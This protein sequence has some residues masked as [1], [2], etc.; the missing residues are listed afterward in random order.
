[1]TH[2]TRRNRERG[3]RRPGAAGGGAPASGPTL[4]IGIV[5]HP[6]VGGSGVVATS[7]GSA[8]ARQGHRVHFFGHEA[9]FRLDLRQENVL[10]HPV[11]PF[12]YPLFR[13]P[14][15]C[16][17][18]ASRIAEAI[19]AEGL[20]LV[21]AHYAVPNAA[22]ALFAREIAGSG[23]RPRIVTTLH[24][25]DIVLVGHDPS[26]RNATRYSMERA[27]AVTAVSEWL[28][29][30][31][32]LRFNLS[33]P[34]RV[35]PNFVDAASFRPDPTRPRP[36]EG[37]RLVHLSNFRAVKQVRHV[38][39][40][41]AAL[42][43]RLPPSCAPR[44]LFAGEGPEL[45]AAEEEVRSLG[46]ESSVRFLGERTDVEAILDRAH[47]FLLASEFESFGLAALEA[48]SCGVVPLAYRTGGLP[49]VITDGV[50]GRL[51]EAG[52]WEA[53]GAAAAEIALDEERFEAMSRAARATAVERFPLERGLA[54][55]EALY[56]EVLATR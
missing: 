7:L 52:D 19:E 54:A 24:G 39:R 17:A 32:V 53:L 23:D 14:P 43:R 1:M 33:R 29:H 49:E 50:D 46:L 5:C 3:A 35:I 56:R 31:T 6:T 18:L 41:F 45:G 20:D 16:L 36:S 21:H 2:P 38:A 51:V 15:H 37:L 8:L 42:A 26:F 22:A 10:F 13:H 34:P 4:R 55:Y 47:F 40:A 27:D 25:T 11:N 48:M 30:E 44:L 9:P 28:A 12:D